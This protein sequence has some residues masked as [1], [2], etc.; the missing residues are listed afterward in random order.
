MGECSAYPPFPDRIPGRFVPEEGTIPGF[1]GGGK[2]N[3]AASSRPPGAGRRRRILSAGPW[4]QPTVMV[5]VFVRAV[6]P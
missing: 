6:L 2:P 4:D 1:P 5:T 3:G